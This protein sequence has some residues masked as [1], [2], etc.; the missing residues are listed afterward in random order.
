[1][2][3]KEIRRR[4]GQHL[5]AIRFDRRTTIDEI[6]KRA[7]VSRQTVYNWET[8]GPPFDD[9]SI[10]KVEDAYELERG[11]LV[12]ALFVTG[13]ETLDY[14]RGK[15]ESAQ[16]FAVDLAARLGAI[17]EEMRTPRSPSATFTPASL[18][19]RLEQ[20][21]SDQSSPDT[22]READQERAQG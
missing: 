3:L 4:A 7:Q 13:S 10:M 12:S 1:M 15:V 2:N 17:A 21:T 18:S 8:D 20:R 11:S 6:A 22:L 16:G 14:W 19:E 5:G 9:T